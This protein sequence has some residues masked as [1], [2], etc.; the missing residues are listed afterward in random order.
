LSHVEAAA[1]RARADA[2]AARGTAD[3]RA[4]SEEPAGAFQI[5]VYPGATQADAALLGCGSPSADASDAAQSVALDKVGGS[6]KQA[7]SARRRPVTG[8]EE[9]NPMPLETLQDPENADRAFT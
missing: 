3:R 1:K 9:L 8:D 6:L 2:E 5:H 7:G 4:L